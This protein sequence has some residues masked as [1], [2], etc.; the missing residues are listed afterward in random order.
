MGERESYVPG[1]FCWAD[2]GTTDSDAAKEFY[3]RVFGF[4]LA[5]PVESVDIENL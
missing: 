1:T 3:S 4:S 5:D 2:L